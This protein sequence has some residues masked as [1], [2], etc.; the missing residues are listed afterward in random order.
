MIRF[1]GTLGAPCNDV[2]DP[3][4]ETLPG[5]RINLHGSAFRF[6]LLLLQR[7]GSPDVGRLSPRTQ[8]KFLKNQPRGSLASR[9]TEIK[10]K[11]DKVKTVYWIMWVTMNS[12]QSVWETQRGNENESL[13]RFELGA[14]LA[15]GLGYLFLQNPGKSPVKG[16]RWT[17]DV[18]L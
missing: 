18:I 15:K 2:T 17:T 14:Y 1:A 12:R 13:P 7:E 3:W 9:R 11:P 8:G 16:V 5:W 10:Y 6:F 4:L